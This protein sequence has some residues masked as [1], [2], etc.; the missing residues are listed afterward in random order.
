MSK[1]SEMLIQLNARVNIV[2]WRL[3]TAQRIECRVCTLTRNEYEKNGS[4]A[5]SFMGHKTV[6]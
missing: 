6:Q 4:P 3:N 5:L 2:D 1:Q